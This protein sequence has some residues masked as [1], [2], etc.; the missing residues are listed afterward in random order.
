MNIKSLLGSFV[1]VE[2]NDV[3]IIVGVN[4]LKF[5][6]MSPCLQLECALC[7]KRVITTFT[8]EPD[9]FDMFTD[10]TNSKTRWKSPTF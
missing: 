9:L 1:I 5:Y 7:I 8:T 6:T 3:Y 10:D 4:K 2:F